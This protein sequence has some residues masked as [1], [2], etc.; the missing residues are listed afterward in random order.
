MR[1][2]N[3]SGPDG[4]PVLASIYEAALQPTQW[5][6]ALQHVGAQICASSAFLFSSHSE[7][8]PKAFVHMHN[9]A[10]E[11]ARDFGAYWH[12][13]DQW[14]QA[15]QRTG[16]MRSGTWVVGSELVPSDQLRKTAFF[17]EFCKPNGIEGMVG[18]VLFDGSEADGMPFTNVCWY[19]PP[20]AE[21][22]QAAEKERLKGLVP[23]LQRAL[24][25]QRRIRALVDDR[26]D[27]A[28]GALRV[29][30]LVLDRK[31]CVHQRNQA[32]AT[33][34]KSLPAGCVSFGQLRSIGGK[35]SPSLPEAMAACSA[36]NPVRIV[37]VLP[38]VRPQLVEAT[39]MRLPLEG[40]SPLGDHNDERFL[41]LVELPRVNGYG[42]AA[43][44]AELFGLTP[45]EVRV[46]GG[47]LEGA[48]PAEISATVG[49]TMNTVRTQIGNLLQKTNTKRQT[50]LLLLMRGMRY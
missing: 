28:F 22:F 13:Q 46:L 50:E 10:P 31:G 35:C 24:R 26:V 20:G 9:H 34:L 42:A 17:N 44:V 40:V 36:T 25:I 23:H 1:Y 11:M 49:T 48:T 29:A 47:L 30:S 19:R 5:S 21:S 8:E 3:A 45:A 27:K 18:G 33:L 6:V 16:L 37:A 7:T 15:A 38:A 14:A 12:T 41:L 2:A 32:G 39:L 43:A 4:D